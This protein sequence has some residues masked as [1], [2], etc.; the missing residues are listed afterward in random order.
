MVASANTECPVYGGV[1]SASI[2]YSHGN[3][4]VGRIAEVCGTYVNSYRYY[5]AGTG[6]DS[7]SSSPSTLALGGTVRVV[8]DEC[9]GYDI[10]DY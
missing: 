7:G 9:D 8:G 1:T 4:G 3:S 6:G 5:C 2:I 10:G